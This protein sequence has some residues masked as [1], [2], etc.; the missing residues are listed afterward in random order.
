MVVNA[1]I[2]GLGRWGQ[3]PVAS[4]EGKS[5]TIGFTAGVT[6]ARAKAAEFA[7]ARRS[8]STERRQAPGEAQNA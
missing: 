1:A 5:E 7:A 3:T 6:R 2:V 8:L 4:V